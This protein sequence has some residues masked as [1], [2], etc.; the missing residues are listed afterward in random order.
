MI[1]GGAIG[2]ALARSTDLAVID[3]TRPAFEIAIRGDGAA[4]VAYAVDASAAW[5]D[6]ARRLTVRL[7]RT[8][9]RR[10]LWAEHFRITTLCD[11]EKRDDL[12]DLIAARLGHAALWHG[13]HE[14]GLSRVSAAAVPEPGRAVAAP[15]GE[16]RV[17][18]RRQRSTAEVS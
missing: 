9:D 5:L 1:L 12:A 14:G 6:K 2:A 13:R 7:A 3:E 17:S 8:D 15:H 10:L 4:T 18:D 16:T 11:D